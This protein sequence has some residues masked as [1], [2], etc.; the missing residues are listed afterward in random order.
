MGLSKD[1]PESI[2]VGSGDPDLSA[3]VHQRRAET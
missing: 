2:D 3:H 1:L